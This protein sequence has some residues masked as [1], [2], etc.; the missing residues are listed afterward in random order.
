MLFSMKSGF[1]SSLLNKAA[2]IVCGVFLCVYSELDAQCADT[3]STIEV[4]IVADN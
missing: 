3:E 2:W 1:F 4:I